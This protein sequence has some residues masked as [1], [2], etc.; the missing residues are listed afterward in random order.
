MFPIAVGE[1]EITVK[2]EDVCDP[3]TMNG[4][5]KK[6]CANKKKIHFVRVQKTMTSE[7]H[8]SKGGLPD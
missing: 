8:Q 3:R 4:M 1:K 2:R 5:Y 7:V 6:K